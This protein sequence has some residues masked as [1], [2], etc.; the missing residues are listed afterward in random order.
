M[1]DNHLNK[2]EVILVTIFVTNLI[3][4]SNLSISSLFFIISVSSSSIF[5][6]ICCR[7]LVFELGSSFVCGIA[8]LVL[9]YGLYVAC[10]LKYALIGLLFIGLLLIISFSTRISCIC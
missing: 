1:L 6:G 3:I 4:S 2:M 9:S 5:E 8:V 10:L 7:D